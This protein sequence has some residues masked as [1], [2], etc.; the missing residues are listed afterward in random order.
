MNALDNSAGAADVGVGRDP[1][2]QTRMRQLVEEQAALRRVAT[3]V[4]RGTPPEKVFAAVTREIARVLGADATLLCRADPDGA[5]VV[6]GT[7]A[8][9]A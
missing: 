8:H 1:P 9:D 4:A 3:L 2:E 6:V 5:A 7:W